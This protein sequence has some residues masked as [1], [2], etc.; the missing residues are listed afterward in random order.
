[1]G[2]RAELY[3][4]GKHLAREMAECIKVL[5][6][7]PDNLVKSLKPSGGRGERADRACTMHVPSHTD[8][9]TK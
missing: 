8:V 9:H 6:C 4:K 5:V 7:N 2:Y 1:M 3:I